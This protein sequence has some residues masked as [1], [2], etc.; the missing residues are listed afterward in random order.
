MEILKQKKT[1]RNKIPWDPAILPLGVYSQ[2][3]I[4]EIDTCTPVFISALRTRARTW[5]QPRCPS[6]EE[7]IKKPWYIY[8][9]EYYSVTKRNSFDS[10]QMR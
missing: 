3:T 7:K 2:E 4:T 1:T 9:V 6:T 5:K 8:T 10:V